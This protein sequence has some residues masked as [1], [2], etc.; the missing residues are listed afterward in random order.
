M[1]RPPDVPPLV[2]LVDSVCVNVL[3]QV[4]VGSKR[5][6]DKFQCHGDS[7]VRFGT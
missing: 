1:I 5:N 7:V 4:T 6:T 3:I 2:F